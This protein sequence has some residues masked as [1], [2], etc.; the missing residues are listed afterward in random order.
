MLKSTE[1]Y[2]QYFEGIHQRTLRDVLALPA[3]AS[4]WRPPAGEGEAAWSVNEVIGHIATTRRYFVRAYRGEGWLS[5]PDPDTTDPADWA[6]LIE[7]SARAVREG[8][9]DTPAGWLEREIPRLGG[10]EVLPGWQVLMFM[11]EHEIHHRSQLDSYAG[12][13]GWQPPQIYG[14]RWEQV[15]A[16]QAEAQAEHPQ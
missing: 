2:L 6:H 3:A 13:N 11:S 4:G 1:A 14:R 15:L 12:L 8:L 16:L 5:P 10:A 9:R 7:A